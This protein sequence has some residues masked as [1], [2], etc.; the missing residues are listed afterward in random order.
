MFDQPLF[1]E[2]IRETFSVDGYIMCEG[3]LKSPM[4]VCLSNEIFSNDLEWKIKG[5]LNKR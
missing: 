2:A 4:V 5:P 3:F 1:K